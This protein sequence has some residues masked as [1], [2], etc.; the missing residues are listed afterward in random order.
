MDIPLRTHATTQD[1][2][3]PLRY[4]RTW[5]TGVSS[6]AE[7]RDAVAALLA[8]VRPALGRRPVQDAQIVVSELVTNA[9]QHAPGPCA[10]R[11]ELLPGASALRVTVT[12]TSPEPPRRHP[13][14]PRRVGGHGLHLVAMLSRGLEVTWLSR[15]KRVSATVPLGPAAAD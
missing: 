7:A 2:P 10:L 9:A 14:D 4:S 15:G 5:G 11:L 13:P 6:I 8:R 1:R 12:D 3:A